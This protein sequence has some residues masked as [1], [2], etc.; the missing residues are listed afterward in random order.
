MQELKA[1]SFCIVG[2]VA[3]AKR[4][5]TVSALSADGEVIRAPFSALSGG[6]ETDLWEMQEE[7]S[8][9][10]REDAF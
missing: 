8:Q 2:G 3:L 7:C 6:A 9:F 1:K 4:N 10:D 5:S